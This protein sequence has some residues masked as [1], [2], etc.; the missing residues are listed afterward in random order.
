MQN[1]SLSPQQAALLQGFGTEQQQATEAKE[2]RANADPYTGSSES[3]YDHQDLLDGIWHVAGKER[4]DGRSADFVAL[5]HGANAYSAAH[6]GGDPAL[7]NM[8]VS[9]AGPNGEKEVPTPDKTR[10]DPG[11]LI[12]LIRDVCGYPLLTRAQK[13]ADRP[14][15]VIEHERPPEPPQATVGTAQND[16][17]P[18]DGC[19]GDREWDGPGKGPRFNSGEAFNMDE[20][21]MC[22][23]AVDGIIAGS[24]NL[25][26]SPA[27]EGKTT[28]VQDLSAHIFEGREAFHG[29]LIDPGIEG[30]VYLVRRRE[31]KLDAVV[32]S[33]QE[34]LGFNTATG[35][36]DKPYR[37]PFTLIDDEDCLSSWQLVHQTC[38]AVRRMY[39][40]H[41][42]VLDNY[43]NLLG[44][45][46]NSAQDVQERIGP[47]TD[48]GG[49][50]I[51]LHHTNKALGPS[52]STAFEGGF[53]RK[54][55]TSVEHQ[56]GI[57]VSS[58]RRGVNGSM[59]MSLPNIEKS[60][61]TSGTLN[62]GGAAQPPTPA[63]AGR[64]KAEDT[65][66][67]EA[68]WWEWMQGEPDLT[69]ADLADKE[70]KRNPEHEQQ[71]EADRSRTRANLRSA[72][73]RFLRARKAD[74]ERIAEEAETCVVEDGVDV[75]QGEI[76]DQGARSE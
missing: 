7:R 47:I 11:L 59:F 33:C 21:D 26:V 63:Q 57:R 38:A 3:P 62:N 29:H 4:K 55:T 22:S 6:F 23:W 61:D 18:D 68:R 69:A 45:D 9:K 39:P 12:K 35:D 44:G 41:V 15:R 27:G 1:S 70:L 52:G 28:F 51:I 5:G 8:V 46:E 30:V 53:Q 34:L 65:I 50:S 32:T 73:N 2:A 17:E 20:H 64:K 74:L 54:I 43:R 42:L 37:L 19:V 71:A 67:R 10:A 25:L 40:H 75:D 36:P 48:L 24:S 49:T 72:A 60:L 14:S 58:T 16:P 13:A 66:V 31:F 76:V 56:V